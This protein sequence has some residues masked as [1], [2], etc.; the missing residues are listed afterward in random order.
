MLT[1]HKM[2]KIAT[3]KINRAFFIAV[4][5]QPKL[6]N[7]GRFCP[8]GLHG[9]PV[10]KFQIFFLTFDSQIYLNKSIE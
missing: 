10:I 3:I 2:L 1:S 5:I 4:Q 6:G 9:Q 8:A 7:L